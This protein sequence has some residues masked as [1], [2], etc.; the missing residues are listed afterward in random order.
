VRDGTSLKG[1]LRTLLE[2]VA[3]RSD[4]RQNYICYA[5]YRELVEDTH[6]SEAILSVAVRELEAAGF[7]RRVIR[8]HQRNVY[9]LNVPLLLK[10]F[11]LVCC[12]EVKA[13]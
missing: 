10:M 2:T 9:F 12:S 8:P 5:S 3:G 11:M 4:P 1:A 7:I 6:Y 13:P